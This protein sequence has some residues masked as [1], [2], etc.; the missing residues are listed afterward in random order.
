M[1]ALIDAR[2]VSFSYPQDGRGLLPVSLQVSGG[3]AVLVGGHS[4]CGKSTLARCLAGLIPHLYHGQFNG[5]VQI[6]GQSTS[7]LAIW[8]VA[9]QVGMV[10]QNP[11][12][13]MLAPTVKDEILFGLENLGLNRDEMMRRTDVALQQFHLQEMC[14]RSPHLLSGG[15]QQKLALAAITARN[16]SVLVLDEPLSMLDT[17]SALEFVNYTQEYL[18][19]GR[20]VIY[21]EHRQ[22]YLDTLA[23][24]RVFRLEGNNPRSVP[25][26]S[27][28]GLPLPECKPLV[29]HLQGLT[30]T[31]GER[32]V[33]RDF[34]LSLPGGKIIAIVGRNGVGKTTLFRTLAGLQKFSG[35]MELQV[36]GVA[37]PP[38]LGI[39][40]Q[41]PDLQ[42]FNGTV[43]SE[44]LYHLNEPDFRLYEWLVRVLNLEQY[45]GTP[46]LLLSEGEKRRVALA[47]MLMHRPGHGLLLDE[48]ALGQD[49]LHKAVLLRLLRAYADA[50]YFVAYA[51]HDM[52]L[53][54]QADHLVLMGPDGIAAQ[55][56]ASDVMQNET[57][58]QKLGFILPEWV[59]VKCSD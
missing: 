26:E 45:T 9:E 39:V 6:A 32:E 42:L 46:P 17:T 29:L 11:S 37:E 47:T 57:A 7:N 27:L 56:T 25:G 15:E 43:R 23:N 59:R 2:D 3:E 48:P 4:G 24:L 34:D 30:V 12:S 16:P 51:T 41:N 55:G 49:D 10:F 44:I 50:G 22:E 8:Q 33:I 14:S 36:D 28:P 13:Q 20:A 19:D 53:A 18:E 31:R 38:R 40:F 5:Q 58:W 21:F 1:N 35:I 52:E 54:A